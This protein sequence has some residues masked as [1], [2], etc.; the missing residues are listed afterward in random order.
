M[1]LSF[2]KI[3]FMY[4]SNS[5]LE[6]QGERVFLT[7]FVLN[8]ACLSITLANRCFQKSNISFGLLCVETRFQSMV[9]TSR[10]NSASLKFLSCLT[11]I[12]EHIVFNI[13][14]RRWVTLRV[15][16]KAEWSLI[17]I[18]ITPDFDI[19]SGEFVRHILIRVFEYCVTRVGSVISW[20]RP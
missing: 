10:K 18:L 9:R 15:R 16:K 7:F 14:E 20:I 19:L 6:I 3:S 1:Q 5:S 2:Q 4:F 12:L 13:V 8:G 17:L 11:S